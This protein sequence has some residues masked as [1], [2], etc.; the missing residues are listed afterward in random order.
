MGIDFWETLRGLRNCEKYGIIE[1]P[2]RNCLFKIFILLLL[3]S[4]SIPLLVFAVEIRNPLTSNTLQEFIYRLINGL[5]TVAIWLS[6]ILFVIA[7]FYFFMAQGDPQ[8]IETAKNIILY[9]II[10]L[11]III[12]AKGLIRL[13]KE[14]FGIGQVSV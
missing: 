10:G 11:I 7:G 6:P 3:I 9:T 2:M 1:Y 4:F 5:F 12:S 14:I 13:L 8:K